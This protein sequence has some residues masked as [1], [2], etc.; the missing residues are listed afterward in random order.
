M[1]SAARGGLGESA[2]RS[3]S[4][5]LFVLPSPPFP[6][7]S[8]ADITRSSL[9]LLLP[10]RAPPGRPLLK[11]ESPNPAW[12]CS[13]GRGARCSGP[14][15]LPSGRCRRLRRYRSVPSLKSLRKGAMQ[16]L[17]PAIIKRRV[18]YFPGT[19]AKRLGKCTLGSGTG[20]ELGRP[21]LLRGWGAKPRSPDGAAGR[22]VRRGGSGRGLEQM[23]GQPWTMS[24]GSHGQR[25]RWLG[26]AGS[27]SGSG[28]EA[29][30]IHH[31]QGTGQEG[32]GD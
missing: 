19:N 7:L 13:E 21:G 31:I 29:W 22:Q 12:A 8:L 2:P 6:R 16:Y 4:R 32:P 11:A 3:I 26:R 30:Q 23:M 20:A 15:S 14:G 18:G 9:P 1:L 24:V 10:R 17:S 25:L 27:G 28:D 5:A